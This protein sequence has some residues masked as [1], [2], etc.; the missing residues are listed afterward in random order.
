MGTLNLLYDD[1]RIDHLDISP[2]GL[3]VRF[4]DWQE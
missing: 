3:S 2:D 1:Q 4:R